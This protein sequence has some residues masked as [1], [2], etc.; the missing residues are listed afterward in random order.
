MRRLIVF[1]AILLSAYFYL[2]FRWLGALALSGGYFW[3]AWLLLSLPLANIFWLVFFYWQRHEDRVKNSRFEILLQTL[4]FCAMGMLSFLFVFTALADL[5]SIAIPFRGALSFG[6]IS[7]SSVACFCVGAAV[8]RY[9]MEITRTDIAIENLPESFENFT[10]VQISDLHIGSTVGPSFVERVV[11]KVN[12][13]NANIVVLTGDI[14]DGYFEPA[15]PSAELLAQLRA[16]DGRF[17]VTGNHEYYWDAPPVIDGFAKLG[18]S[19][20][21]NRHEIIRKGRA[22]LVIAGV[23]DFMSPYEGGPAPSPE[24]ALEGA[25]ADSVK[26]LLAHQPSFAQAAA[27]AGYDLQLSGHTHGGQFFPWTWIIGWFHQFPRGLGR[28]GKTRIYVNRGTGYW[29]PPIRL[30]AAPEISLLRLKRC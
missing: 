24:K 11:K 3:L 18:F 1:L 15:K 7:L 23:P 9:T 8:A 25:P 30:G 6:I 12:S 10:I 27:D 13:L 29:G 5:I 21:I 22:A 4:A 16:A 20:L 19:V 14:V 2:G 26:I 17:Y 28:I